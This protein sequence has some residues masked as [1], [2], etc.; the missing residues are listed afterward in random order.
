M[1][2]RVLSSLDNKRMW[3]TDD[4]RVRGLG[5][6]PDSSIQ[7][8]PV[9]G[10]CDGICELLLFFKDLRL[11]S[12]SRSLQYW[13]NTFS[14]QGL[15]PVDNP[16]G[17]TMETLIL[18]LVGY[19]YN[20]LANV[21]PLL[22]YKDTSRQNLFVTLLF[23][24]AF[25]EYEKSLED[26]IVSADLVDMGTE[27]A[28]KIWE[29]FKHEVEFRKEVSQ[30]VKLETGGRSYFTKGDKRVEKHG[31][32]ASPSAL[33]TKEYDGAIRAEIERLE[34]GDP[35]VMDEIDGV[36]NEDDSTI[37]AG[38]ERLERNRDA[39]K[40][41][42]MLEQELEKHSFPASPSALLTREYDGAIRAEIERLEKDP[43]GMDEID[44][45]EYEDD[46]T[47]LAELERLERDMD[48]DDMLEQ[49][50]EKHDFSA[51]PVGCAN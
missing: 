15:V 45:V 43:N 4:K 28:I 50:L 3:A 19:S 8:F 48:E 47:I 39:M 9:T 20:N 22:W 26:I 49:D 25:F 31:F 10:E 44:G 5:S 37:L 7:I 2:L 13:R 24:D 30:L 17:A 11:S 34:R 16:M 41:D 18:S 36:E 40:E 51:S 14:I 12:V 1:G 42:D 33:L 38:I 27:N 6:S 21:N 35:I 29:E 46:S 32:P 23:Q